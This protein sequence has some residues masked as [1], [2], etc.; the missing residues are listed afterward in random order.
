MLSTIAG[1]FFPQEDIPDV[2]GDPAL[3]TTTTNSTGPGSAGTRDLPIGG[4]W[5]VVI[6]GEEGGLPST[7]HLNLDTESRLVAIAV[8]APEQDAATFALLE[9]HP[10]FLPETKTTQ[11]E[12][13]SEE[14]MPV[15][16]EDDGWASAYLSESMCSDL[17][18]MDDNM[19]RLELLAEGQ[20]DFRAQQK[21]RSLAAKAKAK[22]VLQ[23]RMKQAPWKEEKAPGKSSM[24]RSKNTTTRGRP[25]HVRGTKLQTPRRPA[26]APAWKQE[27]RQ[28][29][30][31]Q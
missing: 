8:A 23:E 22:A 15:A 25:K 14:P 5:E 1:W 29:I 31:G 7:I 3:E 9:S 4:E 12:S 6:P 16:P 11:R 30:K 19:L 21:P 13:F 10:E 17:S 24:K 28:A 26:K 2:P 20:R 18:P 27:R